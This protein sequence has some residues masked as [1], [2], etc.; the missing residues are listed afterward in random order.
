MAAAAPLS[1]R[2]AG[3]YAVGDLI[4]PGN[5][6]RV[7]MSVGPGH[8]VFFR[9]SFFEHIRAAEFPQRPSRLTSAFAF[10]TATFAQG[11]VQRAAAELLYPV[12]IATP[13]AARFNADI[14]LF[15]AA[16]ARSYADALDSAHRYWNGEIDNPER[17]EVLVVGDLRIVGAAL[18]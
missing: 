7:V 6:G 15:D 2:T 5:W 1:Y 9:E 4:H 8:F 12:E 17:V 10:T 16:S 3:L 18:P 13:G 14:G 11:W